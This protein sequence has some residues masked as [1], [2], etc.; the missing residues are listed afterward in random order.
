[1]ELFVLQLRDPEPL[2][3]RRHSIVELLG[4]RQKARS[5]LLARVVTIHA[6]TLRNAIRTIQTTDYRPSIFYR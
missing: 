5:I 6:A 1:L 2:A 4:Q 3:Q